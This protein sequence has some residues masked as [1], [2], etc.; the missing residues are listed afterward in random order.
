MFDAIFIVQDHSC[1]IESDALYKKL[2]CFRADCFCSIS[3]RDNI[4]LDLNVTL[5]NSRLRFFCLE[6][7]FLVFTQPGIKA[8]GSSIKS[9]RPGL[10]FTITD[11][12]IAHTQWR[13]SELDTE[14]KSWFW[15]ISWSQFLS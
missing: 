5:F 4:F 10:T 11:M 2:F 9:Y 14:E 6:G 3:F 1:S 13:S 12:R 8:K 7:A 15:P